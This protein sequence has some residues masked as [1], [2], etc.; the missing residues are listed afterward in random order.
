MITRRFF[1]KTLA[2][3]AMYSGFSS[4]E[5]ILAIEKNERVLNLCN[6]HTCERLNIKYYSSGSYDPDALNDI[7]RLMR[8]HYTDE[9]KPIDV[10]VLN[11]LCSIK[12][13]IADDSE[14]LIIS[15]YRSHTYN[16]YLR[17]HSNGVARDSL[18]LEGRAIDFRIPKVNMHKVVNLARSYHTGGVGTYPDFIHI[19]NGRVRYW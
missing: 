6:I 5:N 12:D 9:I 13:N 1:L 14:I 8:C 11:L 16:E 3:I 10:N 18:H 15:G 4:S 2:I 7:N 17:R 19:D